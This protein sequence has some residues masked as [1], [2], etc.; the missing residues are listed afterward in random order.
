MSRVHDH[1]A[2]I[3]FDS[4]RTLIPKKIKNKRDEL[5][6]LITLLLNNNHTISIKI[7]FLIVSLTNNPALSAFTPRTTFRVHVLYL[8]IVKV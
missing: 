1:L 2:L 3:V 4:I 7:P 6:T 5:T 8:L